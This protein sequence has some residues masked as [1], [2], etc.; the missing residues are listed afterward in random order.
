MT[1]S[2]EV[3]EIKETMNYGSKIMKNI[4]EKKGVCKICGCAMN[5]PCYNPKAGF[6]W[7]MDESETL[8][9][10]CFEPEIKD[11]PRTVHKVNDIPDFKPISFELNIDVTDVKHTFTIGK[12]G[13][14]MS[15]FLEEGEKKMTASEQTDAVKV[16]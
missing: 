11:N 15:P 8:C 4:K 1:N 6:C 12:S 5:N 9:S 3:I 16:V 2:I 7:W 14:G 10:H 13:A